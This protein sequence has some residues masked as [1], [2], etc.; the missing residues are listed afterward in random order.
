MSF[1]NP[2][3]SNPKARVQSFTVNTLLP[4]T[5]PQ[6][7]ANYDRFWTAPAKC[8]VD[9]VVATWSTASS[10]GTLNIEKVPS[11]TAQGS[12]T[13]LLSSTI[14]T[15]GSANTN[16]EGT[17]ET[18]KAT[19]ELAAGDSLATVNTGTLTSFVNLQVTVGLH[20]I[21]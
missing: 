9:F 1:K 2:A 5:D 6:T 3:N 18:T 21:T 7:A 19:V 20:W 15:S 4:G 11:G 10:S 8:V 16:T 14:D 17:L 13:D 12:G